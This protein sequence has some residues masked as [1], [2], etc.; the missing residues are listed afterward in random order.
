[1]ECDV[2]TSET[3]HAGE[4]DGMSLLVQALF[5]FISLRTRSSLG[6][7][8]HQWQVTVYLGGCRNA[9]LPSLSFPTAHI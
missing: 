4:I 6:N 8:A 2:G 5:I 3:V 1:M 9:S 7:I